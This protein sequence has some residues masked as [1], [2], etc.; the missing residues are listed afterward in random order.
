MSKRGRRDGFTLIELLVVIAIIAIL[1]AILFPVFA[2]AR[3]KA[4]QTSCAS[5]LKQISTA[6]LMYAQDYNEVMALGYYPDW[7]HYWDCTLDANWIEAGPGLIDP[8]T[9]N[10][11]IR[12]CPSFNVNTGDR[13]YTG[14]AYNVDYVGCNQHDVYGPG[15][16]PAKIGEIKQPAETVLVCDSAIVGYGG[17][18]LGNNLLKAPREVD[19]YGPNVHFRHNGTANVAYCDGHVKT[20]AQKFNVSAADPEIGDL[21]ADASAYDRQ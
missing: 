10:A 21:S 16:E 7:L 20:V 6:F 5:N 2:K 1:A 15:R 12:A 14:Y 11:Q 8:Y 18:L 13:K 3:E 4:R 9:G 17:G 19:Y